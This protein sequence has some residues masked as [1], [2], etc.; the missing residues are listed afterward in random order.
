MSRNGVRRRLSPSSS[1]LCGHVTSA[2]APFSRGVIVKD[3][4]TAQPV[5]GGEIEAVYAAARSPYVASE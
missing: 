2:D 3:F 5:S 4:V 1:W